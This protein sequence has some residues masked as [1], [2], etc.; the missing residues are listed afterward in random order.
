MRSDRTKTLEQG[1]LLL[2]DKPSGL[3]SHDIV[4]KARKALNNKKI[5]HTGT[6]DPLA[7]GLLVL[8]V[9]KAT[10]LIKYL[11]AL[12]KTYQAQAVLGI[13]TD[14]DDIMGN[15]VATADPLW[16][17]DSE[18]TNKLAGFV[19]K[20]QQ[21]PP[22]Y[23]AIKVKGKKLYEYAR[24]NLPLPE[25]SPREIEIYAIE[26]VTTQRD[27]QKRLIFVNFSCKV[28][29]GTYIRALARD[30]G[31]ILETCGTLVALRRTKVGGLDVADAISL[32]DLEQ[33]SFAFQD[34]LKTLEMP[35]II[36]GHEHIKAVLNGTPL[37]KTLFSFPTET[38]I[39]DEQKQPIAIYRYDEE[40]DKMRM[41]VKL[42]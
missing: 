22:S 29:K 13:G 14:T 16:I 11:T 32:I 31:K 5:G 8:C 26:G 24:Q 15:T 23:S 42:V 20:S 25:L 38:I 4:F 40:K 21:L 36:L 6:L 41:S 17:S 9:G 10:K 37:P 27:E 34:P 7:S 1:G 12:T 30:L 35:S 33:G 3:T 39:F 18:I 28:S 19:G 2:I